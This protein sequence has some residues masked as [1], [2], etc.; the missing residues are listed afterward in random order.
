[1]WAGFYVRVSAEVADDLRRR[2]FMPRGADRGPR[3]IVQAVEVILGAAGS[4]AALGADSVTMLVARHQVKRFVEGLWSRANSD[5]ST[6]ETGRRR[7]AVIVSDDGVRRSVALETDGYGK[8]PPD[9]V[10]SAFAEL[11][12]EL[13]DRQ[14]RPTKE[15]FD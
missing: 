14:S 3:E 12:A 7:I 10:V 11:I 5:D 6:A 4:A 8:H 2:G 9:V 1:M 15:R 13:T